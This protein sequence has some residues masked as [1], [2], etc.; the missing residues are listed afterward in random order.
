[1]ARD[2]PELLEGLHLVD[3]SFDGID[4]HRI[5]PNVQAGVALTQFLWQHTGGWQT[6]TFG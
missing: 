1:M 3:E 2:H 6:N 5:H 4:G